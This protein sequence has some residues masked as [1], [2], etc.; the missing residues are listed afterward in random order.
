M[1][2][3]DVT[4]KLIWLEFQLFCILAV[5]LDLILSCD[6]FQGGEILNGGGLIESEGNFVQ[7]TIVEI[8]PNAN[9]VKEELFAPVLYVM[10][11]KV[12]SSLQISSFGVGK[13]QLPLFIGE[14]LYKFCHVL[15]L[16]KEL[17]SENL[18]CADFERSN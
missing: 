8:S 6:V 4:W 5:V 11:F 13:W 18:N 9:V 14:T 1:I 17:L 12:A 15:L 3:F 7:P 16:S 2:L 10:K